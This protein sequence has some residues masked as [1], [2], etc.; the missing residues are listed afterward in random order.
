MSQLYLPS[1]SVAVPQ[2]YKAF[3]TYALPEAVAQYV[4]QAAQS[5]GC[6]DAYVAMPLISALAAAVGNTQ[7]IQLK[8][9]WSEPCIIWTAVIGE[10]GTHKTPAQRIALQYLQTIQRTANEEFEIQQEAYEA[11]LLDYEDR[12]KAWRK[13]K[14]SEQPTKP[15]APQL[16]RYLCN[17]ITIEALASRLQDNPRGILVTRDELAG[18]FESMNAYKQGS[19]DVAA[20]LEMFQ[21]NPLQ[22]DRKSGNTPVIYVP[23]ASICITGGIQPDAM[24]RALG[25]KNIENGLA[26]RFLMANPPRKAKSWTDTNV[27]PILQQRMDQIFEGLLSLQFAADDEPVNWPLDAEAQQIWI[28]FYNDHNQRQAN[29]AGDLAAAWSKL[30][31]YAARLALLVHMIRIADGDSDA[32]SECIDSL[33]MI[34]AIELIGWFCNETKRVYSMLR[35]DESSREYRQIIELV[36]KKG[37]RIT[38]RDLM[39]SGPCYKSVDAAKQKLDA[40]VLAGIGEWVSAPT[41]Q[42]GGRPTQQFVLKGGTDTDRTDAI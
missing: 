10:S 8:N 26:A 28:N 38:P 3:P 5:I 25:R 9:D 22:V 16:R 21:G 1:V 20:Y 4:E 42:Q 29:L 6:D 19:G 31:A 2:Q 34:Q 13:S 11:E 27:D 35:E 23:R 7:R 33:S 17:D 15:Q 14:N 18:F 39:R 30:E 24:R 37:G 41:S 40:L 32:N 36:Q 12:C